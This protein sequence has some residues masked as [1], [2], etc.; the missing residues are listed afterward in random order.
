[1]IRYAPNNFQKI[2]DMLCYLIGTLAI[3]GIIQTATGI[4]VFDPANQLA[5]GGAN[6]VRFGL[7]RCYGPFTTSINFGLF[8]MIG[9][10]FIAYALNR[11]SSKH[12]KMIRCFYIL[13]WICNICTLSRTAIGVML[14]SQILM[15]IMCGYLK[16]IKKGK[17]RLL[18]IKLYLIPPEVLCVLY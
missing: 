8:L 18:H 15:A 14:I 11:K 2:C 17:K 12:H 16:K 5:G 7:Q 13:V 4:N 9:E 10:C 3:L 6:S 1:M